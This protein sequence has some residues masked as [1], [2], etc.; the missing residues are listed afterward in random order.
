MKAQVSRK[1]FYLQAISPDPLGKGFN[2]YTYTMFHGEAFRPNPGPNKYMDYSLG[3]VCQYPLHLY[4]NV[5]AAGRIIGPYLELIVTEDVRQGFAGINNIQFLQ[6]HYAKLFRAPPDGPNPKITDIR[7][8]FDK[9]KHDPA[10][11]KHVPNRHEVIV[12]NLAAVK[13]DKTKK[14]LFK[15]LRQKDPESIEL[16]IRVFDDYPLLWKSGFFVSGKAMD[17]LSPHLDRKFFHVSELQPA[18]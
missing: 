1:V 13:Q 8:V 17:I 12:A 14:F 6:V 10:L 7:R 5:E 11:E 4:L 2:A 9:H 18:R 16:D 3:D 15:S